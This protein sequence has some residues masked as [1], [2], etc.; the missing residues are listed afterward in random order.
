MQPPRVAGI[1]GDRI[2]RREYPC[3]GYDLGPSR[4]NLHV[5]TRVI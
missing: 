5:L 2:L 1:F 4:I 3:F